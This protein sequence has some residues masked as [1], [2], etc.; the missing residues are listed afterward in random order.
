MT[1]IEAICQSLEGVFAALKRQEIAP[2]PELFDL[3]HRNADALGGLLGFIDAEPAASEKPRAADLIRSL[4]SVLAGKSPAQP[5]EPAEA[6]P[7][8]ASSPPEAVRA[9]AEEKQS[10]STTVRVSTAKLDA[11]LLQ[12]EELLFA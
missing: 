5:R 10:G 1:D 11:V 4:Q 8:A 12:A 7:A 6:P 9:G 3:L 2:S